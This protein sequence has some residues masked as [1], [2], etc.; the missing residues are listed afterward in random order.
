MPRDVGRGRAPRSTARRHDVEREH[1]RVRVRD[2]CARAPSVVDDGHAV[3]VA[4]LEVGVHAVAQHAEHLDRLVVVELAE[5]PVVGREHRDLV[6]LDDRVE[7]RARPAPASR[8]VSGS[9]P[10]G[11]A[12]L[13]RRLRLVRR[14]R[15]G[16]LGA[17]VAPSSP[18]REG[19][20]G[21]P[22]VPAAT[23]TSRP[24]SG[25]WRSCDIAIRLRGWPVEEPLGA[26]PRIAAHA[27]CRDH[28]WRPRRQHVRDRRGDA[29]CRGH[30]DRARHR[31]RRRAPVG[32]HPVE[33]DDR[34]R[35]RAG[36]ARPRAHDGPRRPRASSTSTR[37]ASASRRSRAAC[38]RSI[39]HAA[40]V[41]ERAADPRAPAGSRARTRSWSTPTAASRR[42][43][44][45]SS[46]SPPARGRGC[47]TSC[48]STAS[49]CSPRARRIRRPRSPSTSS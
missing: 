7:V 8:A 1:L 2:R 33:G 35:R 3:D 23:I 17:A 34:H 39:T 36:R 40:R 45:T 30:A 44:P 38:T 16:S 49:A 42:S 10:P 22:R 5:R 12:D 46:W 32:L 21:A 20:A 15:T 19:G 6:G 41:A 18:V 37:C 4:R 29:R 27:E 43:R 28:R 24:L 48:P 11:A 13:R 26:G 31:R 14:G 47:P 25:S 9:P